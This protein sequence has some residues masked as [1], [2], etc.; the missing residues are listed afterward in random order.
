M[1]SAISKTSSS[2]ISVLNQSFAWMFVGLMLTAATSFA[3]SSNKTLTDLLIS[4]GL[5]YF[6]LFIAEFAVVIYLSL[7]I[8]K[9]S[10][11]QA[12][13]AFLIYAILNGVTLTAILMAY[14]ATSIAGVFVCTA[15]IFGVM[16]AIGYTTKKD[17]TSIGMLCFVALIGIIIA[18]L[19]NI[20]LRSSTFNYILSYLVILVF[21]GLTAYDTQKLKKL[22]ASGISVNL[23]ILGA[24]TLY[25]DFI[26]IFINLLRIFGKRS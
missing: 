16:A 8:M 3:V 24:L 25:L 4:N 23:G 22:S 12:L 15:A 9:M 21:L 14:T 7:R 6:G 11:A 1:D 2:T 20:F 10:F 13:G 19:V 18:S 17:L 26:N 5:I